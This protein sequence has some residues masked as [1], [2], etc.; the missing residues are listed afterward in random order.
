MSPPSWDGEGTGRAGM[1]HGVESPGEAS[2]LSTAMAAS[3]T[4]PLLV[5]DVLH[6]AKS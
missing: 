2:L 5:G 4:F 1:V 6:G 3:F